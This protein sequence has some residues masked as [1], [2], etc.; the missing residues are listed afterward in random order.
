MKVSIDEITG[1]V[2]LTAETD[3]ERNFIKYWYVNRDVIKIGV[4]GY[5]HDTETIHFSV[6]E[7]ESETLIPN[8]M[9]DMDEVF[10]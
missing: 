3:A 9:P 4:W 1:L 10:S 8:E 7:I 5:T 6:Q 2:N